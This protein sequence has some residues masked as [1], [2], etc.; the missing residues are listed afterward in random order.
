MIYIILLTI[1]L[2]IVAFIVSEY[3]HEHVSPSYDSLINKA[4]EEWDSMSRVYIYEDISINMSHRKKVHL[5]GLIEYIYSKEEFKGTIFKNRHA[6]PF[7][8]DTQWLDS[9]NLV[10]DCYLK[11]NVDVDNYEVSCILHSY[12]NYK[13]IFNEVTEEKY[14]IKREE[15]KPYIRRLGSGII[16]IPIWASLPHNYRLIRRGEEKNFKL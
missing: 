8:D 11:P 6:E 13:G 16:E 2:I 3:L 9:M 1:L 15:R 5:R 7:L 12:L 10:I 4:F 14:G